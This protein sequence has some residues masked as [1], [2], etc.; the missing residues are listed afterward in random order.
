MV[1]FDAKRV[2]PLEWAGIGAGALAFIVSFFPWY[3]VSFGVEGLGLGIDTSVSAWN[4]GFLAWFAC[5]LLVAAGVVVI[6]P[7][8]GTEVPNLA[9][10]WLGL[11]G[12]ALV[13]IV[14]RWLTFPSASGFGGSAGASFGLF[15]GLVIAVVSGV[16]AF[17]NFRSA[18]AR[19]TA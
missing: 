7:H 17:L 15:V 4:A 9:M 6:L 11:S 8:F 2:T 18:N 14:I 12:L 10:I 19:T 13:F 3:S 1:N 5:L 16:A